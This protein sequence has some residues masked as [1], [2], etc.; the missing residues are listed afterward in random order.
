MATMTLHR[1]LSELKT[2][3]KRINSG[4]SDL[5]VISYKKGEKFMQPVTIDEFNKQ[6][7]ASINS[8]EDLI[9]RRSILKS[10]LIKANA[11]NTVFINDKIM[12]IA[13]AIDYKTVIS[14]KQSEYN[15]LH[16]LYT[17]IIAKCE[18]ENRKNEEGLEKFLL[19]TTGKDSVKLSATD[20]ECMTSVYNKSNEIKLVDPL[21]LKHKL[22]ELKNEIDSF[23]SEIDAV[24]SEVNA[25]VVVEV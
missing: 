17:D 14:Y 25:T 8:V 24:L 20:L 7:Q 19:T 21:N 10:A 23:T 11:E 13:E 3:E 15:R 6:A 4:I 1:V 2:L 12:T 5:N 18:A 9:K 16:R 22:D